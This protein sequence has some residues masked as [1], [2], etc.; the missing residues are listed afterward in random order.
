MRADKF[1]VTKFPDL[2]RFLDETVTQGRLKIC[3][4]TEEIFG[5][6]LNGGIATT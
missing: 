2:S 6:V 4:A 3:I 1:E 5:P